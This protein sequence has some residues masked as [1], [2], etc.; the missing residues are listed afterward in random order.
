[1]I[2]AIACIDK[3]NGIG[4][5]GQLLYH[6]PRLLLRCRKLKPFVSEPALL[7]FS[8]LAAWGVGKGARTLPAELHRVKRLCRGMT[9]GSER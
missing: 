3:N 1:M 9:I 7:C 8:A 4:K 6:L 2:I 5:N